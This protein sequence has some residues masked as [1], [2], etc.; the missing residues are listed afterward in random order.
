MLEMTLEALGGGFAP[1]GSR[2]EA[3]DIPVIPCELDQSW[4]DFEALLASYK[5]QYVQ[6]L[7]EQK[8]L[9]AELNE[10][11]KEISHLEIMIET[12]NTPG[13]KERLETILDDYQTDEGFEELKRKVGEVAG[14]VEAMKKV[15]SETNAERYDKFTCFVCMERLVDLCMNP[16][17][18][19]MCERCWANTRDKTACPGCRQ[20]I[21]SACKIF[22]M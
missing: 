16:C 20:H 1:L 9:T 18:H 6:N 11:M 19:V 15:L 21:I 7:N 22:T 10:K 4:K 5:K 13:L 12:L 17:G 14:R 2:H 8:K 3:P